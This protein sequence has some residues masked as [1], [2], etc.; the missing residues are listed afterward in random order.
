MSADTKYTIGIAPL[1]NNFGALVTGVDCRQDLPDEIKQQLRNALL[2]YQVLCLRTQRLSAYEFDRVGRWFGE[3]QVQLLRQHRHPECES[4]SV[5]DSTYRTDEDKPQDLSLDRRSGWHTDDSYFERPAKITLLQAL[6]I[7]SRGGET[8]FCDARRAYENLPK[9]LQQKI[10]SY[11]A[12]HSY[13]TQ[14]APARAVERSAAEAA[15]TPDVVH[16]LVRTHDE[17]GRKAI[18]LNSNRTDRVVSLS[19]QYSDDLLDQLHSHMTAPTFQYHHEWQVGDILVWDN[20]SVIHAVN[21]DFPVGESRVHQRLL[22]AGRK[23][24]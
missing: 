7:P 1:K 19:R 21:M 3:P 11:Q 2:E 24:Y 6:A 12:V 10:D 20:R 18:Y 14:R 23:P 13:D 15:E 9:K 4:V 22:L 16:P 17:T 8:K 5:F